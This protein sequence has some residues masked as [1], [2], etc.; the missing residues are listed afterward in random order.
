MFSFFG[1]RALINGSLYP[2]LLATL[3][4]PEELADHE[5]KTQEHNQELHP[6]INQEGDGIMRREIKQA[7][8]IMG[9]DS[10]A[11]VY[12][13]NQCQNQRPNPATD[14]DHTTPERS[15]MFA[16]DEGSVD[17]KVS[18]QG[19]ES[20]NENRCISGEL[21]HCAIEIA[22]E[23][24]FRKLLQCNVGVKSHRYWYKRSDKVGAR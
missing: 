2:Q 10:S 9:A 1:L 7:K 8:T 20:D 11:A 23:T 14:E 5:K 15:S 17:S 19:Y 13:W 12:D 18:L 4:H 22:G 3:I 21:C 24:T 16:I 6:A